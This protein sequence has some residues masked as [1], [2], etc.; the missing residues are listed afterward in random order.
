VLDVCS[1]CARRVLDVFPAVKSVV[2][3]LKAKLCP[4]RSG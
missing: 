1:T 4:S 2:E 3:H